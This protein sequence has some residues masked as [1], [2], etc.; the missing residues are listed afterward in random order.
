M[1]ASH[2]VPRLSDFA[3]EEGAVL[4]RVTG[5]TDL[6]D[7]LN[8][9]LGN[10]GGKA[11]KYVFIKPGA[12]RIRNPISIR[13]A[14]D[15]YLQGSNQYNTR[16]IATNPCDA[17]FTVNEAHILNTAGLD[18]IGASRDDLPRWFQT[19][20]AD[21][22]VSCSDWGFLDGGPGNQCRMVPP[23]V[24]A[25]CPGE[26]RTGEPPRGVGLVEY[27]S[28]FREDGGLNVSKAYP[29]AMNQKVFDF[30]N[31]RPFLF[32][33][34]D[35]MFGGVYFDANGPG[36]YRL[37]GV[38]GTGGMTDSDLIVDNDRADV[39]VVGGGMCGGATDVSTILQKGYVKGYAFWQKRGRLRVYGNT[40]ALIHANADIRID[41]AAPPLG[42]QPG[43]HVLAAIRSEGQDNGR[44][45][46]VGL[47]KNPLDPALTFGTFLRVPPPSDPDILSSGGRSPGEEKVDVLV[48][49]NM[50]AYGTFSWT[51]DPRWTTNDAQ[52]PTCAVRGD[53]SCVP[54]P[55]R[56][57][58]YPAA[59]KTQLP[60]L[61]RQLPAC[62]CPTQHAGTGPA[63]PGPAAGPWALQARAAAT[64]ADYNASGNLWLVDNFGSWGVGQLAI[65]SGGT[66]S[67]AHV[68]ALGNT[69]GHR[70]LSE[71]IGTGSQNVVA[72]N[73][74]RRFDQQWYCQT[75]ADGGL[76]PSDPAG[77]PYDPTAASDLFH[78]ETAFAEDMVDERAA[79]ASFPAVPSASVPP[80]LRLPKADLIDS[81]A[82][83]ADAGATPETFGFLNVKTRGARGD[84]LTDDTAALNAAFRGNATLF[85]PAGTYCVSAPV[86]W[87]NAT[88]GG[89][90]A[91]AGACDPT[92]SAGH[93]PA[94]AT[95][96]R[97]DCPGVETPASD[98]TVLFAFG[99]TNTVVQ[100]ITFSTAAHDA[101]RGEP[102]AGWSP[103]RDAGPGTGPGSYPLQAVVQLECAG[104]SANAFDDV[105][106]RG[107]SVGLGVGSNSNEEAVIV[108][109]AVF[110]D[111]RIGFDSTGWNE[112]DQQLYGT[113]FV[114][115]DL[116][117]STGPAQQGL[118]IYDTTV[119]G[120]RVFEFKGSAYINGFDS[121]TQIV[122]PS[123]PL[124]LFYENAHLRRPKSSL[125]IW[126]GDYS[127]PD[128]PLTY[129]DEA[130]AQFFNAHWVWGGNILWFP[131]GV[132]STRI[133]FQFSAPM[134]ELVLSNSD[135]ESLGATMP[136]GRS[137][138]VLQLSSR[139][140]TVESVLDPIGPDGLFSGVGPAQDQRGDAGCA[141]VSDK[142]SPYYM[143]ATCA[144]RHT[145]TC[146]RL[147]IA[148]LEA[149]PFAPR[150]AVAN[151][152]SPPDAGSPDDW[153]HPN[154][155][156]YS[157]ARWLIEEAD[158]GVATGLCNLYRGPPPGAQGFA[159]KPLSA[160]CG[161]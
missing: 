133:N 125:Q 127:L 41:R 35:C 147:R 120:T 29:A 30:R 59:A 63:I 28:F 103:Y 89:W 11:Q 39:L 94:S 155:Y 99:M 45:L 16:I 88:Y 8:W 44:F 134:G 26:E 21:A 81:S 104:C 119:R 46:N 149:C 86:N 49:G 108:T 102:D 123:G 98:S 69:V 74:Y 14:Q 20:S 9:A 112:L 84:G 10:T 160:T 65:S 101:A 5:T 4:P 142:S 118:A 135:V 129:A 148:C 153:G 130:F 87:V 50:V 32:E 52:H 85:M 91:G 48:E 67:A 22:G 82:A 36:F 72:N 73:V 161:P 12:Y 96:L 34:L 7:D 92:S 40:P 144:A 158:G 37:Q 122:T 152:G 93:C 114:N 6:T 110:A 75:T 117:F 27:D 47:S 109:N 90:L 145:C 64:L 53:G 83:G 70:N 76:C 137:Q 113:K 139:V 126:K 132:A 54:P 55:D 156:H 13:T 143:D 56:F 115:N 57:P 3:G 116:T 111:S 60:R 31:D 62:F 2:D 150:L 140:G 38:N 157:P 131:Q 58:D 68:V 124:N 17:L 43:P 97:G 15:L 71:L 159:M 1:Y 138:M 61:A 66:G 51:D 141:Y 80:P 107:G 23:D 100:G 146:H 42:P 154:A 79:P 33:Q 105:V 24:P 95:I 128:T 77:R 136:E 121:D 78:D 151:N 106:F 25:R 18:F 19:I